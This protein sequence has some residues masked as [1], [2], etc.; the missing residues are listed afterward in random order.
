MARFKTGG[1]AAEIFLVDPQGY[2]IMWYP[3]DAN[4]SGLIKDLE[5]LLRISKIG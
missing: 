1:G 3:R 5:R 4:P 2:L